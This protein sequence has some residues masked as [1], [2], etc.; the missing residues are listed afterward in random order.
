MTTQAKEVAKREYDTLMQR[1]AHHVASES[2]ELEKKL[3]FTRLAALPRRW[4][5]AREEYG[6]FRQSL[7]KGGEMTFGEAG[8][9][10]GFALEAYG[11]FCIG[12]ILGRGSLVGYKV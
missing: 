7:Q 4:A 1:N 11:W 8:V 10:I 2:E 9:Y 3:L 6:A 5:H 12:E